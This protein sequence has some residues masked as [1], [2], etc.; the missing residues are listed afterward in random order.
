M[1]CRQSI[2]PPEFA[3]FCSDSHIG[4]SPFEEIRLLD[5]GV[6]LQTNSR[7]TFKNNSIG[8]A[9]L[10][11]MNSTFFNGMKA[12]GIKRKGFFEKGCYL[13]FLEMRQL[14]SVCRDMYKIYSG[15]YCE[16]YSRIN[17]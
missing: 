17:M 11:V 16:I 4:L 15:I 12:M 7:K 14:R 1:E 10:I 2:H 6:R 13:N 9:G 8:N 3:V 5:Y